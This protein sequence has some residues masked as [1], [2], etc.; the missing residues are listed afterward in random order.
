METDYVYPL[1]GDRKSPN[2]WTEMG[3]TSAVERAMKKVN[4]ILATHY[5]DHIPEEVDAAIRSQFPVRLPRD[6]MRQAPRRAVA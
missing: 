4:H 5:P 2:E 3:K 6:A 1:I